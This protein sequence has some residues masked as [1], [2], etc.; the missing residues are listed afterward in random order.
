[1][2]VAIFTGLYRY[3]A[4]MEE[5]VVAGSLVGPFYL[6]RELAKLGSDVHVFGPG[7]S[8]D[9]VHSTFNGVKI[10]RYIPTKLRSLPG[11]LVS[12]FERHKL[13]LKESR[14]GKFE[15]IQTQ[16][17]LFFELRYAKRNKIPVVFTDHGSPIN[18]VI[19]LPPSWLGVVRRIT[20]RFLSQPLYEFACRNANKIVMISKGL[21]RDSEKE[22]G[23]E[24]SNEKL[25]LIHNG[26][27]TSHFSPRKVADLRNKIKYH[28]NILVYVGRISHE[29]GIHNVLKILPKILD[30]YPS[31]TFL[32]VGAPI[33][34]FENYIEFLR[35]L[36]EKEKIQKH[37]IFHLNVKERDLP[38]FYSLG[39][40]QLI[41]SINYDPFP[42]AI[43]E[44][45][46]C[47][48]PVISTDFEPRREIIIDNETGFLFPE[49]DTAKLKNCILSALSDKRK[50]KKMG[51]NS[52]KIMMKK[53][54]ITLTAKKYLKLYKNLIENDTTVKG[55]LN[56]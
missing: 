21:F 40:V 48:L 25:E 33:S 5:P 17:P 56:T 30:C 23:F 31:T 35:K 26:V 13:F 28:E 52:R 24:V 36:I 20:T 11:F 6:S 9:A 14:K 8:G 1:M 12:D 39:D 38:R 3:P 10:H 22:L 51:R 42:N 47:G 43:L 45:M 41:P 19:D 15:I 46:A 37:V 27:D 29:K 18:C 7:E 44:G 4:S 53:Y 49:G 50:L 2:R 34:P 16:S 54:D 55:V 32:I